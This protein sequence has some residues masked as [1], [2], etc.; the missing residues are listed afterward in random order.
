MAKR[1]VKRRELI[2][3]VA[4]SADDPLDRVAIASDLAKDLAQLGDDVM[5]H[6]VNGARQGHHSWVEIGSRLDM[7]RQAVHQRFRAGRHGGDAKT[8]SPGGTDQLA[9]ASPGMLEH[10][11][12]LVEGELRRLIELPQRRGGPGGVYTIWIDERLLAVG[13]A[14]PASECSP[15]NAAQADGV[16]GRLVGVRRQPTV[17][18]QRALGEHFPAEFAETS[19]EDGRK[20][21]AS[22]LVS[23]ATYRMTETT[24]GEEARLVHDFA[25]QWLPANGYRVLA[26][27]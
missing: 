16:R 25:Q 9:S 2:D 7:S 17:G 12:E 22:L 13:H 10:M 5:T 4:K 20:W 21:A 19:G 26:D 8:A 18:I 27:R 14:K 1:A 15:S 3:F 6:F 23:R 24:S 11:Q